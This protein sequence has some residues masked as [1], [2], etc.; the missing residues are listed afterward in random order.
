MSIAQ[1]PEAERPREKLLAQ[2]AA[3][4]S[5]SELLAIFLRT[6]MRGL[7]AVE[8]ARQLMLDFGSLS[9]LLNASFDEFRARRGLGAAKYA[10]LMACKEL[11]QRA[12]A[13]DMSLTDALCNPRQVRDF[14]RL[15]IA[16]K[17]VEVFVAVFLTVQNRVIAVEELFRGTLTETR[18]YPRELVRRALAN[19]A[20]GVIIAH[21]HPSGVCEPS[22]ADHSLTNTLKA[23][24][25]LVDI[26]LLDHFVVTGARAE[27]FAERGWL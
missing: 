15:A 25:Q 23:A 17:D 4:L 5:D 26:R 16:G 2:G 8:M 13:E 24:L 22:A 1:W 6:G 3:A 7:S 19:N 14:L 18:V 12:L 11:A 27:S 20:A 21:N 9:G 10:Q